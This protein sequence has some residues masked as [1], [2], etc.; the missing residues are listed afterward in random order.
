MGVIFQDDSK[1]QEALGA[2]VLEA[3]GPMEPRD[4]WLLNPGSFSSDTSAYLFE[5][6]KS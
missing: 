3:L 5:P 1:N 6:R 4:A 2:Q